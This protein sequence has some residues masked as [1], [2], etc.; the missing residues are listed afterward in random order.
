[1]K[2]IDMSFVKNVSDKI[3]EKFEQVDKDK[4]NESGELYKNLIEN[5]NTSKIDEY[6][7]QRLQKLGDKIRAEMYET[8]EAYRH[9]LK[10]NNRALRTSIIYTWIGI[11]SLLIYLFARNLFLGS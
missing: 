6:I 10:E 9:E 1:M 11:A 8:M 4:A 7:E 3:G 5:Q 2:G